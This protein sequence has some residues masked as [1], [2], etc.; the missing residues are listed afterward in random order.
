M[1]GT[2]ARARIVAEDEQE[3]VYAVGGAG[4]QISAESEHVAITGVQAGD[5]TTAHLV[6]LVGDG[7]ARHGRPPDV[8]VRDEVARGDPAHDADLMAHMHHVWSGGR[9]D[10]ADPLERAGL[11]EPRR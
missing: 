9:L 10:L 8:V 7:D 11:H 5:G 3:L 1:A 4:Q 6:D 2:S